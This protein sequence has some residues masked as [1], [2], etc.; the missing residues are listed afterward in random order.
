MNRNNTKTHDLN[1]LQVKSKLKKLLISQ[2]RTIFKYLQK[3]TATASM[4][5]K[6]TGIPQ[7]N[8][9]RYKRDLELRGLLYEVEKKLCKVTGFKAWYLST[10]LKSN[11]EN[12][13]NVRTN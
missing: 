13:D 6:A 2:E 8:I 7:K 11:L 4:V 9:T 1:T 12:L 3:H 5:S 10:K